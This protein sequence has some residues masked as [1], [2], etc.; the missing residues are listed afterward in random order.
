MYLSR[1]L[2]ESLSNIRKL[3]FIL[4]FVFSKIIYY[5]IFILSIQCAYVSILHYCSMY[6]HIIY[7]YINII[8]NISKQLLKFVLDYNKIL[9][10]LDYNHCYFCCFSLLVLFFANF[11]FLFLFSSAPSLLSYI[12]CMYA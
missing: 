9:V 8:W 1:I 4:F 7:I 5:I 6:V 12:C 3:L 10:L 11:L 2:S